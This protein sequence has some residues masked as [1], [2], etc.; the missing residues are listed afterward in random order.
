MSGEAA[1]P[2]AA[3]MRAGLSAAAASYALAVRARNGMF[4]RRLRRPAR[5]PRPVV[6]IGNIT[7]GG[8]GKTP[9]VRRLAERLRDAG[10]TVA[11][12][13]RGYKA[14]PGTL[15][16]E[17][18]MLA[19]L[20]GGAPPGKPPVIIRAN[21]NRAE[22][23]RAVLREHAGVDVFLLDD[24][25]QHRQLAR[26]FD[27]VLVNAAD[28]FGYGRVLP[29]GLLR[30]PLGGLARADAFLLTRVDQVG[31]ARLAEIR[32]VL[33]QHNAAA[34][35]YESVHAHTGFRTADPEAPALPVTALRDRRWFAF[36]GIGEPTSFVR[37]LAG[38]GG[39]AAG[40]RFFA[41]H[42]A[43]AEADVRALRSEAAEAGADVLVTTEKDWVKLAPLATM[44]EPGLPVWRVDVE[45]QFSRDD[46]ERMLLREVTSVLDTAS[47]GS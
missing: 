31:D 37:Q 40:H 19:A 21:P 38:I 4:D 26:D 32:G 8:T 34:P 2:R 12:L 17:Q 28:P 14:R 1:G 16:D 3:V 24:G 6:S 20:L 5:L 22:A 36:C 42:H 29:R 39:P 43:Y 44:A 23:G 18:R 13:S 30:E 15:G 47:A 25:Y 33:G 45:I 7:A 35:V 9:V 27:L 11:I 46:H 10:R 41:D